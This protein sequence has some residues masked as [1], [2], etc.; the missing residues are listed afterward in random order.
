MG[1][2]EGSAALIVLDRIIVWLGLTDMIAHRGLDDIEADAYQLAKYDRDG[3]VRLRDVMRMVHPKPAN[4]E[5]A[6][7]GFLPAH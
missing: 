1:R 3:I 4:E 7:T 6:T 5:Q 2:S